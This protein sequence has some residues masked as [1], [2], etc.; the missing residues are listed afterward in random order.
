MVTVHSY[1]NEKRAETFFAGGGLNNKKTTVMKTS[2]KTIFATG[3]IALAISTSAYASDDLKVNTISAAA[4]TPASIKKLIVNGNV[5]VTLSQN[6]QSKVLYTNDGTD[7]VTVKKIGNSLLISSDKNAKNAKVTVYIDDIYRIQAS[8]NAL[9]KTDKALN[10]KNLQL[11]LSDAAH[12]NLNAKTENLYTSIKSNSK[13]VL[14]GSSDL[15]SVDMDST[16]R[17]GVEKFSTL[18]TDIISESAYV[19]SRS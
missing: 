5:E 12:A 3:L 6:P 15:Y 1:K 10:L 11:Y 7:E 18:K 19:D 16:S 9:V 2:I 17:I 8:E 14:N 4:V 13:L